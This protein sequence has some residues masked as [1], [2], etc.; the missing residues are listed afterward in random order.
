MPLAPRKQVNAARARAADVILGRVRD[1]TS[2]G[3]KVEYRLWEVARRA[4]LIGQQFDADPGHR[5][6]VGHVIARE[7]YRRLT[8]EERTFE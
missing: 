3:M 4:V 5:V 8:G 2:G 7:I 6:V 1:N